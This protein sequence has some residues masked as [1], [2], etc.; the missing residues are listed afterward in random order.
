[1]K[2]NITRDIAEERIVIFKA[3]QYLGETLRVK[4]VKQ[5]KTSRDCDNR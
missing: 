3:Q 5:Q 1:M 4:R 2:I